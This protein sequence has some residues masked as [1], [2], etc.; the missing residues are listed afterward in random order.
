MSK[1]SE[2]DE[3]LMTLPDVAKYLQVKERTVYSWTQSEKIPA[4]KLNGVWRFRKSEIDEWIE[5]KKK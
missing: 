4:V 5:K 1:K 3:Q 2:N